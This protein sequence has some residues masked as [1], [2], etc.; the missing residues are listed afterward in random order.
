MARHRR[1]QILQAGLALAG[2]GL[3]SG[4]GLPQSPWSQ[5]ARVPRIGYLGIGTAMP[6]SLLLDA[7]RQGLR[8][9]G[10]LEGRTIEIE[11]RFVDGR[12]EQAPVLA[13]ELVSLNVD[14]IVTAGAEASIAAKNAT[15]S[16]PIVGAILATDPVATGLVAS[17]ARPG[18]NV[19]GLAA[20]PPSMAV[21]QLQILKEVL[22]GLDRVGVLWNA[23]NPAKV[24]QVKDL[25]EAAPS[26]GLRVL[27]I[28]VRRDADFT[29]AYQAIETLRPD[30]LLVTQDPLMDGRQ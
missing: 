17:L 15:T 13:A 5:T 16:I 29:A 20:V 4:C 24:A 11:Y 26:L 2:L 1:R 25:Q 7:F 12:M 30:G 8:D 3:L 27:P 18:G 14:L 19:T 22:P 9:L 23:N 10:Y 6:N 21:K 28:E